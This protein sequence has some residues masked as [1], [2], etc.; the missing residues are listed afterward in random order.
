MAAP[1]AL[2]LEQP[3]QSAPAPAAVAAPPASV[4]VDAP[5][6]QSG[7]GVL[8]WFGWNR[9]PVAAAPAPVAAEVAVA[10]V[11]EPASSAASSV[12]SPAVAPL[13]SKDWASVSQD[14]SLP[15]DLE[16]NNSQNSSQTNSLLNS[17]TFVAAMDEEANN[18]RPDVLA[19][20]IQSMLRRAEERVGVAFLPASGSSCNGGWMRK[21]TQLLDALKDI[22]ASAFAGVIEQFAEVAAR[23]VAEREARLA[24][25]EAARVAELVAEMERQA[26]AE[27]QAREQ[28]RELARQAEERAEAQRKL[29]AEELAAFEAKKRAIALAEQK[30]QEERAAAAEMEARAAA[31]AEQAAAAREAAA[32]SAAAAAAASVS[33]IP[34]LPAEPC[35]AF[36]PEQPA[37]VL[38]PS[39]VLVPSVAVPVASPIGQEALSASQRINS[40]LTEL[41]SMG[42][43]NDQLNTQLLQQTNFDIGATLDWLATDAATGGE[44]SAALRRVQ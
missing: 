30:L 25:E 35:L 21:P 15:R 37:P 34:R 23:H 2:A 36:V 20:V 18:G 33:P 9:S 27:E 13:A 6:P 41:R 40:L 3:K 32:A 28:A 11:P 7:A 43:T 4:Q 1:P 44:L 26:L 8:G 16:A 22:D 38:A 29:E 10:P 14:L 17:N 39:P 12:S 5:A 42:F 19:Q 24:A 31:R